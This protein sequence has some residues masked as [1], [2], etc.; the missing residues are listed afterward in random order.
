MLIAATPNSTLHPGLF[1]PTGF[2][3]ATLLADNRRLT[4]NHAI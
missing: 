2:G 3:L 4:F 1:V